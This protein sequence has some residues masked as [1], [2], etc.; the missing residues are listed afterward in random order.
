MIIETDCNPLKYLNTYE[1]SK[2]D[3]FLWIIC[4]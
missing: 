3:M 4:F 2:I 1:I